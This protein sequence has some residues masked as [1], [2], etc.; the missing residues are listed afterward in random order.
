MQAIGCTRGS[1][2][3]GAIPTRINADRTNILWTQ[4]EAKLND[5]VTVSENLLLKM[6]S[7]HL[8][9]PKR[10]LTASQLQRGAIY[11]KPDS[12][13]QTVAVAMLRQ[14][15]DREFGDL[16]AHQSFL[17]L[18]NS[19]LASHQGMKKKVETVSAIRID[20][21][22]ASMFELEPSCATP[23]KDATMN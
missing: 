9:V 20:P 19:P 23:G 13:P 2:E 15:Q 18:P 17:Q 11:M 5:L 6:E 4:V 21:K 1:A 22:L 8:L 3:T 16:S 7:S 14:T 12:T 10:K